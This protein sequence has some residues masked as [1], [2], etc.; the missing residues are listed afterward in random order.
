MSLQ[1][2]SCKFF[3]LRPKS[4]LLVSILV[5]PPQKIGTI[6]PQL[7]NAEFSSVFL[8]PHI[9]SSIKSCWFFYLNPLCTCTLLP[10]PSTILWTETAYLQSRQWLRPLPHFLHPL[11]RLSCGAALCLELPI[12]L[13]ADPAPPRDHKAF[14][15]LAW[16]ASVTTSWVTVSLALSSPT[17]L[18]FLQFLECAQTLSSLL[19]TFS[20]LCPAFNPGLSFRVQLK[21][22]FVKEAP[23]QSTWVAHW[24][25]NRPKHSAAMCRRGAQGMGELT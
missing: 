25:L 1:W 19:R 20:S 13:A 22:H 12:T 21:Y 6:A 10:F 24:T 3:R 5:F 18:T 17:S 11:P 14:Q 4:G 8:T 2:L 9:L 7:A 16:P 23:S 15:G